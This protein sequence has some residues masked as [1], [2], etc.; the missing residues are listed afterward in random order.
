MATP[1]FV[2]LAADGAGKKVDTAELLVGANTVERQVIVHGDPNDPAG[3]G[4]V[5]NRSPNS[6]EY[7]S[8]VRTAAGSVDEQIIL[9]RR[10][11]KLLESNAV[12][13][14]GNRQKIT[15]DAIT[16]SL[17]LGT[18]STVTAVTAIS[19]ALPSGTNTL[20]NVTVGGMDDKQ[21]IDIARNAYANG[22][23]SKLTFS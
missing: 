3:Y 13:D 9:L 11:V 14:V 8:V 20:G 7:G 1:A 2:Q 4:A 12:V 16:A 6:S 19:N 22:I 23:R 21:F 17:T 15:L 18:V 10:I 5:L